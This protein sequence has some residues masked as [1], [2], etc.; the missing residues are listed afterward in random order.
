[1]AKFK[2]F[3]NAATQYIGDPLTINTEVIASIFESIEASP[4]GNLVSYTILYGVN[5]VDWRVKESYQEVL[6][7]INSD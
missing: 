4:N 3:T 7:I 1:M 5:N 6:D 2:Q